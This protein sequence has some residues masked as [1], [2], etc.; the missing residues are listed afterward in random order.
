[1]MNED[2]GIKSYL[3]PKLCLG[4]LRCSAASLRT[5]PS[6]GEGG[7]KLELG[8]ERNEEQGEEAKQLS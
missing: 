1:M 3:V 8:T 6:G 7:P 5:K 4:V 2:R